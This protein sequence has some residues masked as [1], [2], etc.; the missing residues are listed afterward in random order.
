M[1]PRSEQAPHIDAPHLSARAG[2]EAVLRSVP[3]SFGIESASLIY[4]ADATTLPSLPLRTGARVMGLMTLRQHFPPSREMHGVAWRAMVRHQGHGSDRLAPPEARRVA[5][6]A[7]AFQ[8]NT[9]TARKR[10][11]EACAVLRAMQERREAMALGAL[12]EVPGCP[13][14]PP[15]NDQ[16]AARCEPAV[17]ES[18]P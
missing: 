11:P 17:F 4:A 9:A 12:P 5:Q 18:G 2:C 14:A 6:G 7:W 8:V 13:Q 16:A 1:R 10:P 3:Q 15:A